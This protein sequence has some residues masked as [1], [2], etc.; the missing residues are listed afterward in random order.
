[1]A[2]SSPCGLDGAEGMAAKLAGTHAA[3]VGVPNTAELG[4]EEAQDDRRL[5]CCLVVSPGA[6]TAWLEAADT[7]SCLTWRDCLWGYHGEHRLRATNSS[8]MRGPQELSEEAILSRS[9]AI[10]LAHRVHLYCKKLRRAA[11]TL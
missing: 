11:L 7:A 8:A 1:D 5:E 10:P 3:G 9:N 2:G 4:D 6:G